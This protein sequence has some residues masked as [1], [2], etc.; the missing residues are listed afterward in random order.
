[1]SLS[2]PAKVAFVSGANGITGFAIVEHLLQQPKSEWSQIIV[3]SRRPMVYPWYDARIEFVAVDFLDPVEKTTEALKSICKDVTHVYYSSYVHH[4][5]LSRLPEKN[6]PLF[7]NFLDT[8]KAVCPKLERVCLQTGGKYY[9][10]HLHWRPV[11]HTEDTPRYDD[12][13]LNFYFPQEDY[14]ASSQ[15]ASGG[16]WS[17]SI[18]RPFGVI[19]YV[20]QANGMSLGLS[21]AVY[22]ILHVE[23]GAKVQFPGND[24][25][26]NAVEDV[27]YAP[28]M[29]D[30]S[31]WATTQDHT[32]NEAFNATIG[33]L[34]V[35]RYFFP[36][37]AN[38]FGLEGPEDGNELLPVSPAEWIKDK[39]PVWLA[40]VEKYGGNPD[41]FDWCTWDMW[42]WA[43]YRKWPVWA[44]MNKAKRLGWKRQDFA[45]DVWSET[46]KAFENAG[47]LPKAS[48]LRKAMEE[49]R[50]V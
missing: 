38:Y 46:F 6:V 44:S 25:T 13:G 33:D 19:G 47:V 4:P 8:V 34:I 37:L 16:Q 41:T 14:L 35:W 23:L 39:K 28:A 21:M 42:S 50:T 17:Y 31:V 1:M 12:K 36:Q 48:L 40:I 32:K 24:F 3:S 10:T 43:M 20:P 7:K 27:S 11:P 18:I 9:G 30:L 45:Y 2:K 22:L 15:A 5:D 29:A 49:K 26:Y